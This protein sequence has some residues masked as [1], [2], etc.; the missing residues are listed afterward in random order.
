MSKWFRVTHASS[1]RPSPPFQKR[2]RVENGSVLDFV[3]FMT[4]C[5][6]LFPARMNEDRSCSTI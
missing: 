5:R 6:L 3:I 2:K 1:P 4:V